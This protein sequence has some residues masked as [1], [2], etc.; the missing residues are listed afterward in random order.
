MTF[1][2]F[3]LLYT[4]S[5]HDGDLPPELSELGRAL[6]SLEN[7]EGT[8]SFV[9]TSTQLESPT[10]AAATAAAIAAAAILEEAATAVPPILGS[11]PARSISTA[12]L[13]TA[14]EQLTKNMVKLY[15]DLALRLMDGKEHSQALNLLRKAETLLD[16]DA[17]WVPGEDNGGG[18]GSLGGS[19]NLGRRDSYTYDQSVDE[20]GAGGGGISVTDLER[21][22]AKRSH[23]RAITYNNIGCLYKRQGLPGK[24]LP[25]LHN[26]LALEESAGNVHDCASTHLNLCASYSAL[27]EYKDA[28]G[29]AERAIILLQRQLWGPTAVSFQEGITYL[30]RTIATLNARVT[31]GPGDGSVPNSA[32]VFA[33]AHKKQRKLLASANILAMAYHNAAVEH[34]RL[35]RMREAQ[36]SY[37]RACSVGTKFLGAKS[38]TTNALLH[39]QKGFLARLQRDSGGAGHSHGTH[40]HSSSSASASTARKG[41]GTLSSRSSTGSGLA[42]KGRTTSSSTKKGLLGG[43]SSRMGAASRSKSASKLSR[44]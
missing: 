36:V 24:A 28:L 23:L 19:F 26:A 35:S 1:H 17:A 18:S 5:F 16:N 12:S 43:T 13:S 25:Y 2:F 8:P 38:S 7:N 21:I 20:S 33:D 15:N 41:P 3:P 10:P 40:G 39:A 9:V 32:A 37:S 27:N 22:A 11:S 29:H 44:R 6:E 42:G 34:E 31:A 4:D 14:P 30:S